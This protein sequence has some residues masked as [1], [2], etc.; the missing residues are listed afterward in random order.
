MHC[1][2]YGVKTIRLRSELANTLIYRLSV[3]K[4]R[5]ER[6][7]IEVKLS[8]KNKKRVYLDKSIVVIP[9]ISHLTLE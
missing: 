4:H 5:S 7:S 9:S 6:Y 2:A 8:L 1:G 3:A